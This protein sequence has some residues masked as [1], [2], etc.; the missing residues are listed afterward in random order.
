MRA[1]CIIQSCNDT[2]LLPRTLHFRCAI[3]SSRLN[4]NDC[5]SYAEHTRNAI[6][7]HN[8][9]EHHS[10]FEGDSIT[11][12]RLC[13][14]YI[15]QRA[16]N[17]TTLAARND[18]PLSGT[19]LAKGIVWWWW[20][21][22]SSRVW[23][24][25]TLLSLSMFISRGDAISVELPRVYSTQ[26][27]GFVWSCRVARKASITWLPGQSIYTHLFV[28]SNYAI[29]CVCSSVFFWTGWMSA[30]LYTEIASGGHCAHTFSSAVRHWKWND[31]FTSVL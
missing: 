7:Y 30:F 12:L 1:D 17:P 23:L 24:A 22:S 14:P 18:E 25:P 3:Y 9:S 8:N 15:P 6:F 16:V 20:W 10:R 13:P 2:S 31:S 27:L 19:G 11:I 4:N 26:S 29:L 5:W 28:R 21:G